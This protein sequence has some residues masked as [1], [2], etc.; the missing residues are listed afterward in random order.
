MFNHLRLPHHERCPKHS[1]N[2][3]CPCAQDHE[4]AKQIHRKTEERETAGSNPSGDVGEWLRSPSLL[5][6]WPAGHK[7]CAEEGRSCI[8]QEECFFYL[9]WPFKTKRFNLM[10]PG[11]CHIP[12][13]KPA[14]KPKTGVGTGT[15]EHVLCSGFIRVSSLGLKVRGIGYGN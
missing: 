10:S 7:F 8:S 4:A 11:L 14:L 5:I 1:E 3:G 15:Q 13:Y 9:R 6:S 2:T 12:Y